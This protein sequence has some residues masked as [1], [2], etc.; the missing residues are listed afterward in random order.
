MCGQNAELMNARED[1]FP[2]I[3]KQLLYNEAELFLY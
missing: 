3:I 1:K 2:N